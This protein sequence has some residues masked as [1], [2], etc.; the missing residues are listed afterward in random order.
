MQI[1][2]IEPLTEDEVRGVKPRVQALRHYH[3][4]VAKLIARG[5]KDS[6]VARLVDRSPPTIRNF[7][8]SPANQ[9]LIESYVGDQDEAITSLID[10]RREKLTRLEIMALDILEERME[11]EESRKAISSATLL[12]IAANSQDRTGIAKQQVSVNMN[13]DLGSRLD[14]A[15]KRIQGLRK[16]REEGRLLEF[17][18]AQS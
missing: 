3:H 4:T 16:A 11:D 13:L 12:A 8:L 5:L 6:E 9:E 10:Y 2:G 7:R 14:R 1:F 15:Q 17:V 18:R